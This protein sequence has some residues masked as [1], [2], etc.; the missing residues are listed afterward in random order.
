MAWRLAETP[1][2]TDQT[3]SE[4][5]ADGW[6]ML[7]AEVPNDQQTQWWLQGFG[8]SIDVLEP[9]SWR[10]AIHRQAMEVLGISAN[11]LHTT[12]DATAD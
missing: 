4:P 9:K 2:S 1:V 8:A 12:T 10:E 3:L 6:V 7:E 5:D 11:L